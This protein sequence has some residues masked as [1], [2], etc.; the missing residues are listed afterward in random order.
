M[1]E[2]KHG[3]T[4]ER[5]FQQ[6]LSPFEKFIQW[7]SASGMMLMASTVF[8]LVLANSAL[9]H[10]FHEAWEIPFR[11]GLGEW[12]LEK[13]I[14]HW[15]NDGLMA[16]FFFLVGLEIKSEFL[17]GSLSTPRQAALPIVAALGGMVV[18]ALIYFAINPSGDYATG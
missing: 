16:L 18:P 3:K 11:I 9:A 14:H 2:Q 13:S 8:A 12:A 7:E 17:A 1:S 4:L 15:I 6:A 10:A 5:I